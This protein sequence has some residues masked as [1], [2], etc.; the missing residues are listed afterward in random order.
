MKQIIYC[1][2]GLGADERIFSNLKLEG[3]S[4]KHI[5]WLRP[6]KNE[7]IEAYA[8]RMAKAIQTNNAILIG[9][10]FGG[11]IGIEIARQVP[12]KKLILVSSI[13][14]SDELPA[15]MKLAGK[16][17]LNNIFPI[18]FY[19]SYRITEMI[20]NSRLG[21]SSPQEK[22][23]VR[24]YRRSADLVYVQWA[25]N[26]IINWKNKWQPEH[27]VHIH[28]YEDKIFPVKKITKAYLIKEGTHMMIYNKADEVSKII[29]KEIES[30]S[31]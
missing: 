20:G 15:W 29:L 17:K 19:R 1:I 11:I 16:L 26:K 7:T 2:S 27:V 13:K 14:S 3:Y 22:Q 28:G 10:S 9:V 12:L 4:L 31:E 30:T 8:A 5:P 25:I 21:V 23:M 18:R 6:E 24:S